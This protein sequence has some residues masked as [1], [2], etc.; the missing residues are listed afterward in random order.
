MSKFNPTLPKGA[1]I[2]SSPSFSTPVSVMD[3]LLS[4]FEQANLTVVTTLKVVKRNQFDNR[5]L[6][7][8]ILNFPDFKKVI[9]TFEKLPPMPFIPFGNRRYAVEGDRGIQNF[10]TPFE[11][12]D[13]VICVQIKG[14]A[15]WER[16]VNVTETI[17]VHLTLTPYT[18]GQYQG[19]YFKVNDWQKQV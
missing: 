14:P 1:P 8:E 16:E 9:S 7:F 11:K 10:L 13:G 12:R 2:P 15:A 6:V 4:Q 17:R 19:V 5:K 18:Y 3:Q